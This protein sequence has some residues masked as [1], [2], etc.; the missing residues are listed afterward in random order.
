MELEYSLEEIIDKL[1]S[2]HDDLVNTSMDID[3]LEGEQLCN[4]VGRLHQYTKDLGFI[5]DDLAEMI[6]ELEKFK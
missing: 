1:Y 6:Q 2:L 3:D 5:S 4:I